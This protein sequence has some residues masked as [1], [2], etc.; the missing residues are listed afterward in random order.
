MPK[1]P[2][3]VLYQEF[4]QKPVSDD[5]SV[6]SAQVEAIM[7][8]HH[9]TDKERTIVSSYCST[10]KKEAFVA[11]VTV[12]TKAQPIVHVDT[13]KIRE[14][15]FWV[16]LIQEKYSSAVL[17][18]DK[19]IKY[20]IIAAMMDNNCI[21]NRSTAYVYEL[22]FHP[23]CVHNGLI[24]PTNKEETEKD[25][26]FLSQTIVKEFPIFIEDVKRNGKKYR[27]FRE[28]IFDINEWIDVKGS[29]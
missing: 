6:L 23:L 3:R 12:N 5:E 26:I 13:E 15:T 16:S 18:K 20:Q 25:K 29:R 21:A 2:I 9:F 11:G 4:L 27:V 24:V 14:H 17:G 10:C 7:Q 19:Y 28:R 22:Y 1:K 8:K